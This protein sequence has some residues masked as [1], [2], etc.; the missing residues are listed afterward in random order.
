MAWWATPHAIVWWLI[1]LAFVVILLLA[2]MQAAR[3]VRELNR[4][5][6]RIDALADSPLASAA[7]RVEAA[8]ARIEAAVAQVE[9]LIERATVAIAIIR[10][11]P[12]PPQV[13]TAIRRV[14]AELAAFRTAV[15]R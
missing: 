11:G 6:D 5:N 14:A 8:L 13:V 3:A 15:R 7:P 4:F 12:L 2:G 9:P 1:L 10:R